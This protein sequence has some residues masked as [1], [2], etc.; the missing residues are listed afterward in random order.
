MVTGS[1]DTAHPER[2]RGAPTSIRDPST[3]CLFST[4]KRGLKVPALPAPVCGDG[5]G[6]EASGVSP[7]PVRVRRPGW[8]GTCR[9]GWS[10]GPAGR[11][12]GDE[13]RAPRG[14]VYSR[15]GR[16]RAW[17]HVVQDQPCTV[18]ARQGGLG[19]KGRDGPGWRGSRPDAGC[20][21]ARLTTW[22][23]CGRPLCWLEES[24]PGAEQG[25]WT[26]QT[27][28]VWGGLRARGQPSGGR[29]QGAALWL[30]RQ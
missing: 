22:G 2:P 29:R 24:A 1:G 7:T 14:P 18:R 6:G 9:A 8:A 21:G 27:Q 3:Q 12:C 4:W 20:S 28:P 16:R 26:H 23:G 19:H 11:N 5:C 13:P 30:L 25:S 10:P 15:S 17:R